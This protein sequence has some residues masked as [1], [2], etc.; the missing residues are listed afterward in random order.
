MSKFFET[1]HEFKKLFDIENDPRY[2]DLTPNEGMSKEE[3]R[4]NGSFVL[5]KMP[6]FF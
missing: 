3:I 2:I 6:V 5:V 1:I 4:V